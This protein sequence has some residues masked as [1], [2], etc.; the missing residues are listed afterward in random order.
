MK[1]SFVL[2]IVV[3]SAVGGLFAHDCRDYSSQSEIADSRGL[4]RVFVETPPPPGPV[5]PVAEFETASQVLIRYPLGFPT[6]LVVQFANVA[7]VVCLVSNTTV[8]SQ[9][10][11]AFQNAGVDMS[12]VI[13]LI[14]STNTYWTRDYGPW[15]IF[16]GNDELAIVDFPYNRPRPL[17]D[18][19]PRT[20]ALTY[21]YPLYGMNVI[22]TGGNY[23][24]DGI[25][26]AAQTTLVYQ[27][28]SSQTQH[29]I[30]QKMS[31]YMGISNYFVVQDPNNT[32]IDHI[33]CWG[34]FLAPDKVLIRSVPTTHAQYN[35]I[36]ATA[37][38]FAGLDCAWG[39][40]YK[41][42]RVNTPQNQPY[43]N[44][45]F[46]NNNVFVPIMNSTYDA[47]ALQAYSDA[48]PGYNIIGVAGNYSTP[49]E[50]TDA[51][52][53]RAH[54]IPDRAMLYVSHQPYFGEV[55]QQTNLDFLATV[56]A[57]SQ[58][59]LYTDSLFVSY[60]I[61]QSQW[62]RAYLSNTTGTEFNTIISNLIP[63]DTIRYFI[64]AADQSGRSIDHPLTGAM[65]PHMFWIAGD[66]Q[67]PVITHF[68]L[69]QL[70][71]D[72]LPI[73]L[74]AYVTDGTGV[75]NVQV[76][77]QID[78]GEEITLDMMDAGDDMWLVIFEPV[79][80]P[81]DCHLYYKIVATDSADPSNVSYSPATGWYDVFIE[82]T[83]ANDENIPAAGFSFNNVYPNPF[84]QRDGRPVSVS[85][86]AKAGNQV[87]LSIYNIKGQQVRNLQTIT[88]SAGS[89]N[90]F[91]DGK[92]KSGQAVPSGVY[93]LRLNCAEGS[94]VKKLLILK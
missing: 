91:W 23:M 88:K 62:F 21:D 42:Y 55:A 6:A 24:T 79:L 86:V 67:P 18:E 54:E 38:Y 83:S 50:S 28:N 35:A 1:R 87:Q 16:D 71:P 3:L 9:A 52:H 39:Y 76:V 51:L 29:Q 30:N 14:A 94:V 66:N 34:K 78:D 27:E 22:N 20:F 70:T 15:F 75:D 48:L 26:S 36:E 82:S 33:D 80:P 93:Y 49:W 47:Q 40:P 25:N 63:G 31:S 59:P 73:T 43:T 69:S 44:S 41:V 57:Y 45:I 32:Y 58:M 11:T 10:T 72:Q 46:L 89:Q 74:F 77:Y 53:C 64:H 61:N 81:Q 92:D 12:Q 68:P 37:N 56:K 2:M 7:E 19:I 8:Q 60:K 65:D 17:D 5:R 90:L 84:R 85:Y 4:D 13:F